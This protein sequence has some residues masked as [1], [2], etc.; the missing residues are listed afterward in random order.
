MGCGLPSVLTNIGGATE[1]V[2]DG[3]NGYICN[4]DET[5]S[6]KNGHRL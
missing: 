1:M 4:P 2:R 6:Q 5:I 3:L